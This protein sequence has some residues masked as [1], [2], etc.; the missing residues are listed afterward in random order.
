MAYWVQEIFSELETYALTQLSE[1]SANQCF[2]VLQSLQRNIVTEFTNAVNSQANSVSPPWLVFHV[3]EEKL[4]PNNPGSRIYSVPM[5]IYYLDIKSRATGMDEQQW[6]AS[7]LEVLKQG[8]FTNRFT[9]FQ[10]DDRD[11][12]VDSTEAQGYAA[13][14]LR[15][16]GAKLRFD[17][18][19]LTWVS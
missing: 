9:T 16:W 4:L 6:V 18:G 2:T 10:F 7:R 11:A 12:V 14:D 15:I 8:L 1:V 5:H 3:G 19:L 17:N 13:Q